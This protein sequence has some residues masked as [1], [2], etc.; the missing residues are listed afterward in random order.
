[1]KAMVVYDS[2]FGN[3]EKVAQAIGQA[4][5]SPGDVAIVRVGNARPEQLAGLTLL[6]VGSPTQK[7]RPLATISGFLK[8]IPNNGLKGVK[9]AAF[10]TRMTESDVEKIRILAFFVRIFG[11]AAKPIADRLLKKGGN[12]AV[13]PEGFYVA[14]TEGPLL[15]GELER[16]ADWARR[17][18]AA[19]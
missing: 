18:V 15:E 17:I 13:P 19:M 4:L 3:T 9:V 12:L 2:A 8:G 7:F 14:G 5:G 10:D 6:V 1:M 11:Y 16:A